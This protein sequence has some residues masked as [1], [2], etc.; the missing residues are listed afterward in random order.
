MALRKGATF[1]SPPSPASMAA[2]DTFS[3]PQLPRSPTNIDD[4][5]DANRRRVALAIDDITETLA[6][7]EL[8]ASPSKASKAPFR[9]TSSPVPRGLLGLDGPEQYMASKPEAERRVLRPRSN[10]RSKTHGSDSGLGSSIT[11]SDEKA[12]AMAKEVQASRALTGS[13]ATTAKDN[14]RALSPK[15]YRRVH[16]HILRPL[17]GEPTFKEFRPLVLDVPRRIRSKDIIC[18]RDLEKTL[19][20]MA[21]VSRLSTERG[22]RGDTYRLLFAKTKA[23]SL[24][25]DFCLTSIR[26]I[27]A[28]VELFSDREQVR[29]NDRPYTNGYF[30]DLKDQILEYG[31]Q[32]YAA[33]NKTG[34]LEDDDDVDQYV[35]RFVPL[36]H[37]A[38]LTTRTD[39]IK[40]YGGVADNGRP[41]ELVRVKKDGTVISLATGKTVDMG[42][43]AV[44]IKRSHSEQLEDQEEIMRSMARR[45]KNATPEELAPKMCPHPGCGKMFKRPCDL[46]KHE[47]THSRPW[48]CP[49]PTCKYHEFGWPTEKEMDRH[50]NDKHSNAPAMYE[51]KFPPCPYK[52]K[53][54]SN[55]KQ[56]MEKAHGWTYVRTKT[57][58]KKGSGASDAAQH[59]PSLHHSS[60]P[61]TTPS[62]GMQT[63]PEMSSLD[64]PNISNQDWFGNSSGFDMQ[65]NNNDAMD[66]SMDL[67]SPASAAS[68]EQ[69]PPYQNGSTFIMP[70]EE[71]IYA[72]QAQLGQGPELQ[73]PLEIQ[74]LLG[75]KL[76]PQNLPIYRTQ[77]IPQAAPAP[78]AQVVPSH[79]SPSAQ[80]NAMLYTPDSQQA[81]D[82]GFDDPFATGCADFTL[83]SGQQDKGQGN[84]QQPLFGEV[85]AEVP[86]AGLGFSQT[87]QSDMLN[88]VD[89]Y[90]FDAVSFPS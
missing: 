32:L 10:R 23:P 19:I 63:P 90:S 35:P 31:R 76:L 6:R 15:A 16:E 50:V 40:L 51:C 86:S 21:P 84:A 42:E 55:C 33:K 25:L 27:Q 9:D 89:W 1:H 75:S 87:S 29:P 38:N 26:C 8:S 81:A 77:H 58:G 13:A 30:I 17:L 60:T 2:D 82:E 73:L 79:F 24:Y 72:A 28:T 69:Y 88:Q 4:I 68:Y 43:S 53:R 83:F 71:D 56:H 14:L 67:R 18:L 64:Y 11:S 47:K 74:N 61:S 3:P 59:T 46:T 85:A 36:R 70:N 62:Y 37:P 80:Q 20:F 34:S 52:S 44:K 41:A 57:N 39:E 66:I 5:V 65:A 22:V 45:K 48:K 12:S 7:A 78:Q 54:E 49:L